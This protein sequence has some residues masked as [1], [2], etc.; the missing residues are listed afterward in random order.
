MKSSDTTVV[1]V[2]FSLVVGLVG[3]CD[4]CGADSS[5]TSSKRAPQHAETRDSNPSKKTSSNLPGDKEPGTLIPEQIGGPETEALFILSGLK[6][7]LEPCGCS[8][9]VLLGGIERLVGYIQNARELYPGVSVIDTGD[10]LF[11]ETD[12]GTGTK[13]QARA[14]TKV[15]VKA[16]RRIDVQVTVPGE[17]DLAFGPEYYRK[18]LEKA[19][20]DAIGANIDIPG[21]ETPAYRKVRPGGDPVTVI[22][23]V[24][25]ELYEKIPQVEVS[26]PK[27]AL[28]QALD[29]MS[30]GHSGPLVLAAHGRLA[31]ARS[32]LQQ[33]PALDFA[34]VGEKP[35][36][37]DQ[38][39]AV[40]GGHTLEA[41]DQGRY[42]GI[43]KLY[44]RGPGGKPYVNASAGSR[45]EIEKLKQQVEHVRENAQK[46]RKRGGKDS[47]MYQKL[48]QR[49]EGLES[50]IERL[51]KQGVDVPSNANA[52]IYKPV[53]MKPGYPISK[54]LQRARVAYNK[55]LEKL[56][57]KA[58]Q[59]V[60]PPNPDKPFFVG[61]NQCTK[62]HAA[63]H[64]FWKQTEHAGAIETLE[65]RHKKFDPNCIKCHVVGY[66]KPGGSA[67]G[68]L[69]YP[70]TKNDQKHTKNLEDVGCETCH[71]PGSNHF[72]KPIG[73]D[74]KPRGIRAGVNEK[75]CKQCHVKEHSPDFEFESYV[76]QIV[77]PGH[78]Q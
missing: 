20:L 53:P 7:Y 37:T 73:S 56:S 35:R 68:K 65:K 8:A 34:I 16:Y 43:L 55:S 25:P 42:V 15:L 14:K 23:A 17:R 1:A 77:G 47:P 50:Q 44:N 75:T 30:D 28:E 31:F 59:P 2:L 71:G 33:F 45:T 61:T 40:E 4:G 72:T 3:G 74:G 57:Q 51:R 24:E 21:L 18:M 5:E 58:S 52:F 78:G 48:K 29:N 46:L 36:E 70:F 10:F 64:D 76:E 22:G 9:D 41:F 39:I 26:D 62:C 67:L 11:R 6:G 38:V 19:K 60:V 12:I 63:E 66:Q 69:K 27:D 54:P 32:M 49:I 13:A